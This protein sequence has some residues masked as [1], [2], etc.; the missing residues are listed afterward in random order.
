M[1]L[2]IVS[3]ASATVEQASVK[4]APT[5]IVVTGERVVRTLSET[6]SSVVVATAEDIQGQATPDRLEQVLMLVPNVQFGSEGEGPT[7]RGQDTTGVLRDVSAF[8]GGTRPRATV[9]VDGRAVGYYEYVF[10]AASVWDVERV[11]VFRSPQSTTQ[12]R[13]SIAGAIF[14]KTND[15]TF[16]WEGNARALVGEIGTRQASAVVSG[17]IVSDQFAVRVSGDIKRGRMASNMADGIPGADINRDDHGLARIKLL[18]QPDGLPGL[19][20]EASYV[21]VESQAPQFEAVRAPFRERRFPTPERTNGVYRNKVDSLTTRISYALDPQLMSQTTLSHGDALIQRFGLPGLGRTRVDAADYSIESILTWQPDGPLKMIGGAHRLTMLQR[22]FI[23]IT[24]LG[25]GEGTF[26]DRQTSLGLF[27]EATWRPAPQ[28]T[29]TAGL[30]YQRDRQ[31]REGQVGIIALDYDETFDAWLP[32]A[33]IAYSTSGRS[34]F[35]VLVQRAF[36]PGGT[37]ISL[38]RRVKDSFDAETLWSYEA[39]ARSTFAGGKGSLAANL[40]YNDINNAQRPQTVEIRLPDGSSLFASEIANAPSA[41]SYGMEI[42]AGWRASNRFSLRLGIGLLDTKMRRTLLPTD[43]IAGK[44]FQRSPNFSAAAA[45]DWQPVNRL[46]LSAQLRTNSDYFSDD[47]NN[48]AR[49]IDGSTR[50]D[51]RAAY[52]WRGLTVFG[53]ARNA[54]DTFYLTYLFTPTF[55]TAGDPREFGVGIEARF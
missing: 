49:R 50:L 35:G 42:E 53:H 2:G 55:A 39:F 10:G 26:R 25:I 3:L 14:V 30:R 5:E 32:K 16:K 7:I 47:A 1:L 37:T 33:S 18:A 48:P 9:T 34:T 17:P 22:Q 13:N 44:Q 23:D 51:A 21:H 43:P 40:F 8:L 41:A 52:T 36:N 45:I 54:F 27:G 15:P 20:F 29:I 4:T 6:P 24:G 38:A 19:R 31:D 12:G 11:E 28:L 46:R